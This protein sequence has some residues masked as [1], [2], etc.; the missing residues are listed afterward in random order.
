MK[1]IS[2]I[3]SN[4]TKLNWSI[5]FFTLYSSLT[6]CFNF[7]LR[8]KKKRLLQRQLLT[9]MENADEH[10]NENEEKWDKNPER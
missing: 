2:N 10:K 8:T 3:L 6:G 9:T 4:V 1:G 5:S 7:S